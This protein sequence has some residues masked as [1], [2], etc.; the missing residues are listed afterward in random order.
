MIK[1]SPEELYEID[2]NKDPRD[3]GSFW[4]PEYYVRDEHNLCLEYYKELS[5]YDFSKFTY[6]DLV[7]HDYKILAEPP[8]SNTEETYNAIMKFAKNKEFNNKVNNYI[9][10]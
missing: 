6:H 5:K 3:I 9:N 2:K 7:D 8:S 10:D 1:L 4:Y